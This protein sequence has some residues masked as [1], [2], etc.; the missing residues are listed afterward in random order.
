MAPAY[1]PAMPATL[2]ALHIYP[3]KSCGGFSAAAW[4]VDQFGLRQDRRW[5]VVNERGH[6]HTQR[7]RPRLALVRTGLSGQTLSLGAPGME[8]I[9]VAPG[10][11]SRTAV[12]IWDDVCIAEE[13]EPF[14]SE[15]LSDF[16]GERARLVYMPDSTRRA[17]RRRQQESI[18]RVAFQDAY[19][20]LLIGASS[21]ADL[22]RRMAEPLPML[23]F[24]PNLVVSGSEPY[25][26]DGWT[27]LEVGPV[28]LVVTKPCV[29]CK[30]PTID[31]ETAESGKEP[32]TTLATYRRVGDGVTFGINL[33][34]RNDGVLRVGDA[35]LPV[36]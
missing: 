7:T 32:L 16:L 12:G 6:F 24:R 30:I 9:A 1:I 21:L 15:W 18:A 36:G 28:G 5:M 33:S 22:N 35:V 29:R 8:G 3:V 34:H 25:A 23:R 26:E 2:A 11:G 31:Q 20:F 19:P 14:G 27:A 4:D 10:G 17:T 13:C